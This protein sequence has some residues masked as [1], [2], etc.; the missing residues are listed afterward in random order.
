MASN[1]RFAFLLKEKLKIFTLIELFPDIRKNPEILLKDIILSA[2]LMPFFGLTSLLSL[3][4]ESR[5]NRFKKL[6]GSTRKMVA[7]DSTM[8]RVL[9]WLSRRVAIVFLLG[10]LK[11]FEKEDLSRR[12][13]AE[14]GPYRR[15][16][17][18]DGSFMGSHYLVTLN[19]SGKTD[20]PLLV[21]ECEKRGKELPTASLLLK[22]AKKLLAG[23]F[24]DLLL[25]D[26]LY[27]NKPHFDLVRKQ[28]A[29]HLLIKSSDPSFREVLQDADFFFQNKDMVDVPI[30]EAKGFDSQRS[31]S[32]RIE[33]TSGEFAGYPIQIGHLREYYPKR[34]KNKHPEAWIVTTDLSLCSEELR[35][36]AHLRWHVENNVFKRISHLSG[37]KRFYFKDSAPFFNLLRIFFAALAAYDILLYILQRNEDEFKELL[38]DIKPTWRNI[39]SQIAEGFEENVF[40]FNKVGR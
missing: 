4:R 24:P 35:E 22:D 19:L 18:V 11:V 27:F 40:G 30:V 21:Q 10:L 25:F 8:E 36:A 13:L 7:S 33:I 16:G 6:F 34:I 5:T 20:Y 17:I 29:T 9:S 14:Q 3:D 37:T 23:S 15:I 39:F 31:C 1:R 32:W 28:L 38:A 26:S 12:K 2:F